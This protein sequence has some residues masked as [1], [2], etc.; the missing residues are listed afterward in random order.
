MVSDLQGTIEQLHRLCADV[1]PI[2]SMV[3]EMLS[4]LQR[5]LDSVQQLDDSHAR[6]AET[7]IREAQTALREARTVWLDDYV[8]R[9][10]D[11]CR[12]IAS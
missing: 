5:A 9:S 12:R 2:S 3:D 4:W 8:R 1:R 7:Q 10:E 11:L 6:A